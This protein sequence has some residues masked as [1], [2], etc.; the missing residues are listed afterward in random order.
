VNLSTAGRIG[1]MKLHA[2]YDSKEL[3]KN[4]RAVAAS[5]LDERLLAEIRAARPNLTAEQELDALKRMRSAH[6][7]E[8]GA[9][10]KRNRAA[11]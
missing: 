8:L 3:T 2:L 10:P 4:G 11:R 1:A 6:F 9:R 7:T 5:K